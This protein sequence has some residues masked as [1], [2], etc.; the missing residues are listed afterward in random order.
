MESLTRIH[1]MLAKL[2]KDCD[3]NG[4]I[5]KGLWGFDFAKMEQPAGIIQEAKSQEFIVRFA[6]DDVISN[7]I[8]DGSTFS[9]SDSI[10]SRSFEIISNPIVFDNWLGF[11]VVLIS[12]E[13][14]P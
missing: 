14:A 1:S 4:V 13:E 10:V 5:I 2:G 6:S 8:Q 12:Q 11:N 9:V 7:S 3:F